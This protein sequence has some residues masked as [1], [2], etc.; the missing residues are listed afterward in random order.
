MLE[1]L[2]GSSF[3]SFE[4]RV[5]KESFLTEVNSDLNSEGQLARQRIKEKNVKTRKACKKVPR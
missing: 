5:V 2:E 1:H 4:W 3:C